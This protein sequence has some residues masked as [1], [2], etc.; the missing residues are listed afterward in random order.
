[1]YEGEWKDGKKHGQGKI[2]FASGD[3]YTGDWVNDVITGQGVY[4]SADGSRYESITMTT[5]AK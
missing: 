5:H 3:K 1:V 4:N 2:D